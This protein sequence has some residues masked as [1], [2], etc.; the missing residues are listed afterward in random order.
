[1]PWTDGVS[2]AGREP[3]G[4]AGFTESRTLTMIAMNLDV[5]SCGSDCCMA[6]TRFQTYRTG[7]L[8]G[9]GSTRLYR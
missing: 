6:G 1:M 5:R 2:G 7:G 3:P 4:R 8:A 9:S